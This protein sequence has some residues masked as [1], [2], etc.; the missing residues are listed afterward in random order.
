MLA[1]AYAS[2][3]EG[4]G[5][6]PKSALDELAALVES[7]D[8]ENLDREM[9]Q[10]LAVDLLPVLP[11]VSISLLEKIIEESE[12]RSVVEI[13]I[14]AL[15]GSS[16]GRK[17]KTL[18]STSK[19]RE[20][21][22]YIAKL[23][24]AWLNGL[25]LPRLLEEL[26]LVEN[27]KA[28]EYILRQWCRQNA[29]S[30]EVTRAIDLWLDTV[31]SDMDF[32]L[33][34]RSLRHISEVVVRVPVAERTR[35][36]D[37]LKVPGF[38]ALDSPKEE[39][40]RF[41][42]NLAE[43]LFEVN[44]QGAK[45]EIEDV[46]KAVLESVL[47]LDVRTFCLARLWGTIGKLFPNDCTWISDV[48]AQFDESFR[49]LLNDSA[50][51]LEPLVGTIQA[52]VEVD[53]VCAL[54]AASELNTY[55]RRTEA[56]IVVL[57]TALRKRGGQE[58]ADFVGYA[59]EQL[60]KTQRSSALE[61][62]VS[63]L[64]AREVM[65]TL[66]NLEL[67]L[68]YSQG[69][70]DPFLKARTLSNLASL[71]HNTSPG[72]APAIM[73][74]AV[75]AWRKEDDLKVRLL[76][77]FEIVKD[78][79]ELNLDRAKELYT[80]VQALKL[81]PGSQLAIG[82][83]GATFKESLDLAIRAVI[84]K[85]LVESGDTIRSLESLILRIPSQVIQVQLFAK[86]AASA[87]RVGHGQYADEL[88]RTKV[89]QTIERMQSDSEQ[90]GVELDRNIALEFSLPVILEYDFSTAK[91]L[92]DKLPYPVRDGA[93][94]SA[95]LWSLCRSYLGDHR[96][97]PDELRAKSDYPRLQKVVG[98][99]REID[100][101]ELLCGTIKAITNSVESSF[102]SMLNLTQAL[103]ILRALDDLVS[104]KLPER[105]GKNIKHEGF[106]V[107]SEAHIHGARSFVYHKASNKRGLTSKYM[108]ERWQDICNRAKDIRNTAD[109]VFVMASIVP[110]M[111]QYYRRDLSP[112]RALLEEAE[113]QV[114]NIP[115]LVDR[116]DRLETIADSWSSLGDKTQAEVILENAFELASQLESATADE[117][118]SMLVQVA[119]AVNPDFADDLVSRLDRKLPGE[120]IRSTDLVLW[121]EKLRSNPSKIDQLSSPYHARGAVM[122]RT[123]RKL[124]QDFAAGRGNAV[125]TST[126]ED[127]LMEARSYHPRVSTDVTHWAIENLCRKISGTSQQ[128]RL[129]I[130]LD[131]AWL[132]NELANWI[133][134]V[135]GEGIPQVVHDSFPGLSARVEL[136]RAG[137]TDR[138]KMWMQNWLSNHAEV[139][140][141]I[142]DPYFG[143]EELEYLMHV[144]IDCRVLVVTTD[145]YLSVDDD[146]ERV[147]HSLELH[148]K[149]LTSRAYPKVQFLIVPRQLEDRFHDRAIITLHAGLD[150]GQSLNGLG[151]SHGKITVLSEEEAKELGKTYVDEMLNNA[152]WFLHGVH[153]SILFLGV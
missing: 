36:I 147:K 9:V 34:L 93:W 148:W 12:K 114:V 7:L 26:E 56:T 91:D 108:G 129:S 107:L 125:H 47:D 3:K 137:E 79:A 18:S 37:R 105:T 23:L 139:Y 133:S 52:L 27:T 57:K 100:Y 11:D 119:Y 65:L 6:V 115:T 64:N 138:A 130:F 48:E 22:G 14:E 96:F 120:V 122:N 17:Q 92:A 86:L 16:E 31:V 44:E 146:P 118:L 83:L 98:A 106:R 127:W 136:F 2:M 89:I 141:K 123:T 153:P 61:E 51:Q 72:N 66:S 53:P 71:F 13:A 24:S 38:T 8:L 104:S 150:I 10:E 32:V 43:G 140:L 42:L 85:D 74:Q 82:Q 134:I 145:R 116:A 20:E 1:K 97:E 29:E 143:P 128:S 49:P 80:E 25:P 84:P 142:C 75:E 39:W 78:M 59:L 55:M 68:K 77:G 4:G 54:T 81:Q 62:I 70:T 109:R 149:E 41:H 76:L 111:I 35:L 110:E 21:L 131:T 103:D 121:A 60:D 117:R 69:I 46:H 152:T 28:R 101:D 144:P 126:L 132:A 113:S 94:Y 30:A 50:D 112:A 73:E 40:V 151:K 124:L 19:G 102:D 99:T 63:E 58:I 5:R 87:Y 95:V 15:E 45:R 90:V 135:K 88:V 67:L 33:L